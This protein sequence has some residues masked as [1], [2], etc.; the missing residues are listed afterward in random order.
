MTKEEY[1]IAKSKSTRYQHLDH[2]YTKINDA[3]Q[4]IKKYSHIVLDTSTS[5]PRISIGIN[6]M[7][8]DDLVALL[9]NYKTWIAGQMEEL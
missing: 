6:T 4:N 8:R 2:E 7:V 1:E 9:E 5:A 3:I